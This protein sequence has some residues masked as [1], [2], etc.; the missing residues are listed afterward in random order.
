VLLEY[1]SHGELLF[2]DLVSDTN[3]Y[4]LCDVNHL[5]LVDFRVFLVVL[6]LIVIFLVQFALGV[7]VA[8]VRLRVYLWTGRFIVVR[9]IFCFNNRT[10]V[11]R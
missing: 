9:L 3:E 4:F 7:F 6:V 11:V 10:I 8:V 1:L 2:N 5:V